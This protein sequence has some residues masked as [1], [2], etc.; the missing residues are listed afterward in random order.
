MQLTETVRDL[1][2]VNQVT[3]V[4]TDAVSRCHFK[5]LY[6]Y[7]LRQHF[8]VSKCT[9]TSV[10]LGLWDSV[11]LIKLQLI[12]GFISMLDTEGFEISKLL[13]TVIA[14]FY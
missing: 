10:C 7:E 1:P 12:L 11:Q 6:V 3:A 13:V 9:D 14:T 5:R 2:R 4:E 8:V